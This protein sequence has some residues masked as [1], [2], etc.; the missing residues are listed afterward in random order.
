MAMVILNPTDD[1]IEIKWA[2]LNH[3]L[4]ADSRTTFDKD[5]DGKQII[6]N[7]AN[8]GLVQLHYGDEGEIELQKIAAGRLKCDEFW[9]KQIVNQNQINE[10]R[11]Q[12][13][14]P[15]IRP[16]PQLIH[17][18][19]RLG[20]KLLEPYKVEDTEK[21]ELSLLMEQNRELKKKGEEKDIALSNM[22]DQI[23]TLTS[24]FKQ[25]M[26]LAGAEAKKEPSPDIDIKSTITRMN[27]KSFAAWL[28][29]NWDGIKSYPD[30]VRLDIAEKHQALFGIP[31]PDEK[32]TIEAAA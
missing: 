18:S 26:A 17:H 2:G 27:K 24:N 21:K 29:K 20:L 1:K 25:L 30:D 9:T 8:R 31:L 28:N 23:S 16:Q 6:H 10:E 5:S 3:V 22:Q 4:E 32:P 13:N 12:A 15:F 7:Y 19:K 11:Q 14:R